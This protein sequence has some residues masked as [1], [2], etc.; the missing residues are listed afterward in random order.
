MKKLFA[1]LSASTLIWACGNKQQGQS[2]TTADSTQTA[3][4]A[5]F[6]DK[7]TADSAIAI[8]ELAA[9]MGDKTELPIKLTAT[10][11]AVC[12][13]KGCWMDLKSADSSSLRVTFKDYAFFVPK[14][15]A[16][17]A[18][19]VQGIAKIEETSVADLK[20]YAKDAGKTKEEI[21]AIKEPKKEMVFEA[22]GVIIK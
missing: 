11:D 2:A 6:G 4:E 16:G 19:I 17:K 14:D 13:K 22:S 9:L 10:V 12:Q 7:I 15:A 20:E 21:D 18:A 5:Y 8:S 3:T 1:I